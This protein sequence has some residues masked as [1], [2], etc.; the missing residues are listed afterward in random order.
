MYT[1]S[2]ITEVTPGGTQ[3]GTV[4]DKILQSNPILEGMRHLTCCIYIRHLVYIMCSMPNICNT[5]HYYTIPCTEHTPIIYY[6]L[7]YIY[8]YIYTAF[9]NARTL[10]NDNSSRFGKFIELNFN[11]R[12]VL[13]GG[14]IRTYLL[15]KVRLPYQQVC[16][17]V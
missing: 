5:S 11:K 14:R 9:G 10:R 4:M 3:T 16:K 7:Y 17:C 6:I 12:G 13:I 15:E 1:G 8:I 2:A